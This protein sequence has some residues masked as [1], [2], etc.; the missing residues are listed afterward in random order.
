MTRDVRLQLI[1]PVALFAAVLAAETA[2][3]ALA[4][5]PSSEMLWYLNLGLF[6]T[7]QKSY[8][9]VNSY[10][11]VPGFQLFGIALP[12]LG[13]ACYGAACRHRLMLAI[14]SSLSFV[15]AGLLVYAW[16]MTQPNTIQASLAPVAIP[17]GPDFYLLASLIGSSLLS[18]CISHFLYVRAIRTA[19]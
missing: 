18:F 13:I 4:R 5:D 3:Y 16:V 7:F 1:G 19:G 14:A 17:S 6:G 8:Y 12:V 15:Y 2:A 9:L 11:E 10:I